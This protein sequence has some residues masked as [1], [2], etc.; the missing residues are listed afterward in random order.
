MSITI[1]DVGPASGR[2]L[3]EV[4]DILSGVVTLGPHPIFDDLIGREDETSHVREVFGL[5]H[6]DDWSVQVEPVADPAPMA[7]VLYQA[8]STGD[9]TVVAG[10][11]SRTPTGTINLRL[12]GGA[13]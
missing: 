4:V 7:A 5:G 9:S 12:R 11:I 10:L 8:V 2:V 3:A 6:R 1:P 13:R